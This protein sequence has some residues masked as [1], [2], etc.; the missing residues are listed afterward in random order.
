MEVSLRP[1]HADDREFLFKL[2][3]STRLEEM[4][5]LGWNPAQQ[6]A[7]LRMQFNAQQHWYGS[8]YSKAQKQIVMLGETAIGR[9]IV[10]RESGGAATLV[11]ISLLPEHRGRGIGGGL[12]H[13]L[14]AQCGK[15]GLA[16]RLQVLKNNPAARLYERLGFRK[17]GADDMYQQMERL[18]GTHTA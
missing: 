13:D 4:A 2:Y 6:E 3:A 8:A 11:D 17:T 18:P 1:A 9:M 15:E 7:F 10:N 16:L 14:I 12:L 5:A